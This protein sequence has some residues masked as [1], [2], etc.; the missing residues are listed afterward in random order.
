VADHGFGD[1]LAR[2][3]RRRP[4]EPRTLERV[5]RLTGPA[6]RPSL[7]LVVRDPTLGGRG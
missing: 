7:A 3:L 5:H 4:P 1:A 2:F 6:A